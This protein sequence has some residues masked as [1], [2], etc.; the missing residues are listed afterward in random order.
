MGYNASGQLGDGT[1]TDAL[2]PVQIDT[3]VKQVA[4][5]SSHS[6]YVKTNGT[7]WA[8]GSNSSGQ[9]GDGTTTARTTPVQID[10]GVLQVAAGNLHS[11]YVK[12]DRHSLGHGL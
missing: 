7:L 12:T 3:Y 1:T 6:L 8:M 9:L 2:T 5:G 11:L 4:A 10:T